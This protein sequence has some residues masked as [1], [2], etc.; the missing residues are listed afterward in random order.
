MSK[1]KEKVRED[2]AETRADLGQ[3]VQA[4]AEKTDVKARAKNAS[5]QMSAQVQDVAAQTAQTARK[6][7]VWGPIGAGLLA[8]GTAV[9]WARRRRAKTPQSRA[10]RAW[11]KVADPVAARL[12]R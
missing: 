12:Q 4:L 8:A 9:M 1:S 5:A 10:K 3:T 7:T 6:P 2:I 11:H